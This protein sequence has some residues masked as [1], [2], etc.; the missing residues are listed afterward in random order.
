MSILSFGLPILLWAIKYQ[1]KMIGGLYHDYW[2]IAKNFEKNIHD[3]YQFLG[4]ELE[5]RIGGFDHFKKVL[6]TLIGF[7]FFFK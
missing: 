5:H 1:H 2:K 3:H 4:Y 6:K 7:R